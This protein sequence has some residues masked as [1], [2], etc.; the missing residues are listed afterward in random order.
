MT[1]AVSNLQGHSI[2]REPHREGCPGEQGYP[3]N[4]WYVAAFSAELP[5]E[6]MLRREILDSPVLLYRTA[7]GAAVALL[8]RCPHRGLPL[9]M[10]KRVGDRVQCGYHGMEFGPEGRCLHVPSQ[11]SVPARMAV[12]TFPLIERWQ[13]VW[14]WVGDPAKA[15]PELLPDHHWLGLTRPDLIA[16]PFFMMQIEANYQY[17]H[18]NLLDSTHVSFL[19]SG[20]LDSGDEMAAARISIQ[21]SGQILRIS[22]DTPNTV[23]SEGVAGY[24]RVTPGHPYDRILTNETYAPSVSI[25]KQQI[26]D[27]AEP[28]APPV[29]LYAINALT[30]AS[31]NRTYVHHVQIT[32]YDPQWRPADIENVRSIVAQDKVALE[33]VQRDFERFG[34]SAEISVKADNMGIRCRRI[35]GRLV[36]HETGDS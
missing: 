1:S 17:M 13:W 20:Q 21:E 27:P 16:T 15:D 33:A 4:Q 34:E 7:S 8:D 29:E 23:F 36:R 19:H 30:P 35:I 11:S 32:S 31:R 25:G 9:S 24:F 5:R 22:Y 26:R 6:G 14:I 12:Q 28:A 2:A 10:G 3:R 18:E